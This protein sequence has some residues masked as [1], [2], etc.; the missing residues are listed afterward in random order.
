[1]LAE[2]SW[3]SSQGWGWG[4]GLGLELGGEVLGSGSRQR[5]GFHTLICPLV[6]GKVLEGRI[7]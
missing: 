6:G 2:G 7:I 1:M 4:P 3:E 5:P